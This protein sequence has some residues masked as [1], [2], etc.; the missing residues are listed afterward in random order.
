[1]ITIETING[2]MRNIVE[3]VKSIAKNGISL[4]AGLGTIITVFVFLY[5][6]ITTMLSVKDGHPDAWKEN[7]AKLGI[8]AL[9]AAV[10]AGITTISLAI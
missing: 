6:I 1:M 4:I 7:G 3:G 9:L 8:T 5:L 10:L 2:W